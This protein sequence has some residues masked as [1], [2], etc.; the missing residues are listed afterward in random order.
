M[1]KTEFSLSVIYLRQI[2]EQIRRVGADPHA[3]LARSGLEEAQLADSALQIPYSTLQC[4]ILDAV[5]L[6]NEPALGLLVGER[7]VANSHGMLGYAAMNSSTLRQVI[8]LFEQYLLVRTSLVLLSHEIHGDQVHLV[9]TEPAPLG[10]IR[11]SVL[12]AVIL[13]VKNLFDHVAMGCCNVREIAFPFATPA[14][15]ALAHE[16]F[17]CD[18]H[19]H[20][21]WAGMVLPLAGIDQ[22]LKMADPATYR[23]AVQICQYEL[24]KLLRNESLGAKVR[25]IMLQKQSGFPSLNVMARLLHVTPRTLHRRLLQE[26]TS[27]KEILEDIRHTLAIEFLASGHLSIQEISYRLGYSDIANFRR[28]FKRWEKISPSAY[29]DLQARPA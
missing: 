23:E 10:D 5:T 21:T 11:R 12:E 3:W 14:Y 4:L 25:R 2:A 15:A 19:Y 24:D 1:I 28:A 26:Q 7:L 17:K 13:T 16:L 9:F 6:T 27:Y 29:R 18:V 22:P 20:Q 8:S